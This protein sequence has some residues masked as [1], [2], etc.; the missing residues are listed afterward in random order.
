MQLLSSKFDTNGLICLQHVVKVQ[1]SKVDTLPWGP[2]KLPPIPHEH[3]IS[4]ISIAHMTIGRPH[5]FTLGK[6]ARSR[7]R[8]G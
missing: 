3:G 6:S 4:G 1:T 7:W 8:N 5:R 2:W